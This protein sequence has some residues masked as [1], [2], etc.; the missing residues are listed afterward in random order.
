M[1]SD[2]TVCTINPQ[3]GGYSR[4]SV[5]YAAVKDFLE[6]LPAA[7]VLP[8]KS[9]MGFTVNNHVA[10]SGQT[11]QLT[12]QSAGPVSYK[13]RADAMWIQV[14]SFTGTVSSKTPSSVTISADP[15]Q[16]P[17]PGKYTSTVTI[18]SGAAA[19]QYIT[20]TATVT[21]D[22]SNVVATITPN[23]VTQTGGQWS[24]EVRLAET[25]GVATHITA[26]KFDGTDYTSSVGTWF[27]TTRIGASGSI[28]APL[29]GA[30][31]FPAGDQVF[32]FWGV[33][34]ASGTPW[35]CTAVVTF[36]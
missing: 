19:P 3:E 27:G 35:Y 17:Q 26:V 1:F 11:V 9:T 31:L 32:E 30:G 21:A 13:L 33:D 2:G 28:V 4:F 36:K 25:A 5:T 22:Q 20:V 7:M 10:P 29:S 24:F 15:K 16:L 12:T 18:L 34:D 6:N 23:A 14:S 8:A